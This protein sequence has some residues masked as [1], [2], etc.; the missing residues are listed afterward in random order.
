MADPRPIDIWDNWVTARDRFLDY[1]E[2]TAELTLPHLEPEGSRISQR[3]WTQL[4]AQAVRSLSATVNRITFPPQVKWVKLDMSTSL[5][6]RLAEIAA[7]NPE[8]ALAA[9]AFIDDRLGEMEDIILRDFASLQARSRIAA[10]IARNL[11]EGNTAVH[12]DREEIRIY[13]LRNFVVF[14]EAGMVRG[15]IV[16]E[17]FVDELMIVS[18]D[19]MDSSRSW[20]YTLIDYEKQEVWQQRQV[21]GGQEEP[22]R[23]DADPD[24]FFVFVSY[25]PDIDHYA[26]S[27]TWEH[28]SLITEL[29]HL[30]MALAEAASAASWNIP[31]IREGSAIDPTELKRRSSGDPII[32]NPEDLTWF[33]SGTKIGD[34]SFVGGYRQTL[35]EELGSIFALGIKDRLN[36]G[37]STATEILQIA[38]ELDTHTQ[39]LLTAYEE[40]LQRPLVQALMNLHGFDTITA[41]DIEEPIQI[42]I[43][44]GQNALQRETSFLRTVQVAQAVKTLDP[45]MLVDGVA[46][47][48]RGGAAMQF[49]TEGLFGRAAEPAGSTDVVPGSQTPESVQETGGPQ[50]KQPQPRVVG[51]PATPNGRTQ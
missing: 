11:I 44:T 1:A 45:M 40:T 35:R 39:D 15:L 33:S 7:E 31:V 32:A 43:T 46:L 4:G 41:P 25:V 38:S 16:R 14:R 50:P 20:I 30:S 37:Q 22:R 2:Q 6:A 3:P 9:M 5:R 26:T 17:E 18:A 10:A 47:M 28:L 19:R 24:E 48:E 21:Q 51:P 42:M 49:P 27:Y 29:N 8:Q 36:R 23:V 34:W 12:V 13:P